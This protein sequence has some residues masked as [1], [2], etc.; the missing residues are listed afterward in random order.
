MENE[1]S[2]CLPLPQREKVDFSAFSL[3]GRGK[4]QIKE[5]NQGGYN[6]VT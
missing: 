5:K 3:Q 6:Q 2:T 1:K 4:K